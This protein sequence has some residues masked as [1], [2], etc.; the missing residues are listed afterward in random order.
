MTTSRGRARGG[1]RTRRALGRHRSPSHR[2][3]EKP[4]ALTWNGTT[5]PR[6]RGAPRRVS[7][8]RIS[9]T[10]TP[11]RECSSSRR[12]RS[13]VGRA[14]CPMGFHIGRDRLSPARAV[15]RSGPCR[16]RGDCRC[17]A[18]H[19]VRP[20]GRR[21]PSSPWPSGSA[22][23]IAVVAHLD[24]QRAVV[25]GRGHLGPRRPRVLDHVGHRLGHDEVGACLDLRRKARAG[26]VHVQRKGESRERGC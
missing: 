17:A 23:P 25:D 3:R 22:P 14:D 20:R 16:R 21:C 6:A 24:A 18:V 4:S 8:S 13:R 7:G 15:P 12:G 11:A 5:R 19:R 9:D 26:D 10:E 1:P 2:G